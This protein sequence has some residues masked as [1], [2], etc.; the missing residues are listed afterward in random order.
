MVYEVI[1]GLNVSLSQEQSTRIKDASRKG[2]LNAEFL[3]DFLSEEKPKARKIVFN[4]EKIGQ[5]FYSGHEYR[6]HR[7]TD[8]KT[9]G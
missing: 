2:D 3:R 8:R 6:S 5:L 4:S 7:G 9:A 1:T